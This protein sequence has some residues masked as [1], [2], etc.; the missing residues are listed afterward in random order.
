MK[1]LFTS[2]MVLAA[3]FTAS[4]Q[5]FHVTGVDDATYSDGDIINIG[6]TEDGRPGTFK[7]DPELIVHV[8]KATS[9]ITGRSTYTVTATANE[10]QV[11]QFCGINGQCQMLKAT[12]TTKSGTYS[13]GNIIP[14]E[15]DIA[16]TKAML[17]EPVEVKLTISDGSETMNL[18]LNFLTSEQSGISAPSVAEKS[19]KVAGRTLHYTL[20][21]MENLTLY[22]ISGRAVVNRNVNGTGS[23]SLSGLPAGVYVYRLGQ[24]TGKVLV[25]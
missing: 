6:Y 8:D 16:A 9:A 12:E 18:T 3:A 13:A 23:I 25:H 4:A 1:K 14:L 15:I 11:V 7:W 20:S 10:P 17:T 21:G 5:N 24:E 19:I 2:L 22:N